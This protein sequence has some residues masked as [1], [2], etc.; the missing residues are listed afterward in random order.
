MKGMRSCVGILESHVGL[1]F[2]P[3]KPGS[4]WRV[5]EQANPVFFGGQ[6][7]RLE[8]QHRLHPKQAQK[9]FIALIFFLC[10]F[11][12]TFLPNKIYL[13]KPNW[14]PKKPIKAPYN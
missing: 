5:S 7:S 2:I 3:R 6:L 1:D 14:V 10:Y 4:Q 12:P 11:P 8:T 13:P 9:Y